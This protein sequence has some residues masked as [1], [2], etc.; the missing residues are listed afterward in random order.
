MYIQIH[1]HNKQWIN[2]YI[3]K[4]IVYIY[5]FRANTTVL[6]TM[7]KMRGVCRKGFGYLNVCAPFRLEWFSCMKKYKKLLLLLSAEDFCFAV[8]LK[9]MCLSV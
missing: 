8:G 9:T 1:I 4:Y 2:I 7:C 5:F 3:Y 6:V